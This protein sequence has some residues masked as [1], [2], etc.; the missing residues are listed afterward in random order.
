MNKKRLLNLGL[1]LTLA[2]FLAHTPIAFADTGSDLQNQI[3]QDKKNREST[4][5]DIQN[6]KAE[7]QDTKNQQSK[8]NDQVQA[9]A[10][11]INNSNYQIQVKQNS[12]EATQKNVQTLKENIAM[13]QNRINERKDLIAKRARAAYVNSGSTSYLQLLINANNFYDFVNRVFL[14]SQIVEQ[15]KAI[16]KQQ[17]DDKKELDK[18]QEALKTTLNQLNQDLQN[19]EQLKTSLANKKAEQETLLSQLK[20][21]AENISQAVSTQQKRAE[22][23]KQQEEAHK[24]ELAE[25]ERQLMKNTNIPT[26]IRMFVSP[27]QELERSTGIPAAIT[28]AQIILESGSGSLSELATTGKNLFGIKGVGPA[29][30]IY[31]T[32]HEVIGGK[33]ITVEAGFKKYDSYYQGMVDHAKILNK[34]RYQTFLKNAKSLEDYAYG[35]QDGGYSTDPTYAVKLLRI[36][37]DYGLSQYDVGSF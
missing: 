18:N 27:A 33:T 4:L 24:A 16:L 35:I 26:E 32:T 13:L 28:L 36:I 17:M 1:A 15:D 5:N 20:D 2:I 29:G 12:I 9:L 21:K 37:K 30:T 22:Y 7:L 8:I 34:P 11:Q 23:Y 6:K 10:S 31:L 19:L 3:N 25:W 14:V